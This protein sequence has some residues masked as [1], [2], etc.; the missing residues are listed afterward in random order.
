MTIFRLAGAGGPVRL[1]AVAAATAVTLAFAMPGRAE[2]RAG[3]GAGPRPEAA[4]GQ[5]QGAPAGPDAVR[6]FTIDVPDAVLADLEIRLGRTRLPDELPGTGWDYG[7][8]RDYLE[9]LLDYWRDGFDWRAQERMLNRFDQFK[10]TIDGLDVHFIHQR[11]PHE[12]ALP[13]I[14]THGWPGSFME[15][16]KM[17]GPLTDPTAHGGD[18]ADAFHV[19]AP[20]IPGYGFSD[21]PRGRGYNPERMARI[22]GELMA[23]LGYERYGTQGG[24]WGSIISRWQAVQHPDRVVGVHL[25]FVTAGPPAG[26][27]DPEDGVPPAELERMRERQAA[28]AN[29]RGYSSIQGTKPQTLGYGLNDSPAG[30]AAWIVEKFRTW[31]DCDGDVE[32]RFTKDELLTNVTIY[33]V[34]QTITS[35]ARIYYESRHTPASQAIGYLET[36]TGG[37][38]FP[39][40]ITI[41]PRQWAERVYNITHWTE[42][43]RGGHFAALEQPELLTDD[44]RA[45]F[46]PLR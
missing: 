20:S 44:I 7:T 42:M 29:E 39:H 9:E 36:P 26:V 4:A 45:F 15:F 16:H 12:D 28:F 24:D 27:D 33:W 34:T 25:N 14:I 23:R 21:K 8:N 11:S 30:L 6:P 38:I 31:C 1:A 13:L 5:G 32:S 10:T 43:P 37:A 19:V 40:E 22:L 41:P 46:R 17:I 35:S 3:A 18:A 2:A